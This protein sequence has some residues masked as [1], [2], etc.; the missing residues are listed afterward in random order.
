MFGRDLK[1]AMIKILTDLT[2][3]LYDLEKML[4]DPEIQ[5]MGEEMKRDFQMVLA[6]MTPRD[7]EWQDKALDEI[8][9]G[10]G[11]WKVAAMN[12]P[13]IRNWA[14]LY[15]I[16]LGHKNLNLVYAG[17]Y[18]GCFGMVGPP[19]FGT[20]HVEEA[21][22]FKGRWEKKGAVVD[23][24]GDCM[25]GGL[26]GI[27]GGGLCMWE[28]FIHWDPYDKESVEGSFELL[29]ATFKFGLERKM[30]PGME[31]VNAGSRGLD[32]KATRKEERERI[33]S[34]TPQPAVFRYQ[35]KIKEAFDP[36]DL[37]DS[38]YLTL[39]EPGEEPRKPESGPSGRT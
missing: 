34:S 24:G 3:T 6:G 22:E 13:N 20:T 8:L 29:E 25:I 5:K 21:G 9:A 39:E 32:G 12:D 18:D 37:G 35:R 17:G 15:L 2:K 31:R 36:N 28:N 27:G 11:G 16:R 38:Y 30:G 10:T 33:L 1:A 14:L 4:D 26:G 7:I 19:D 23:A